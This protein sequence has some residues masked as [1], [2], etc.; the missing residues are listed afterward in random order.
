MDGSNNG[1][2]EGSADGDGDGFD[3]GMV[4]G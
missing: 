1:I 3:V 4:D 2:A